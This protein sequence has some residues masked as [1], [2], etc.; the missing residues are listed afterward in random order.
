MGSE[1]PERGCLEA[2]HGHDVAGN[3]ERQGE[4]KALHG[5]RAHEEER[6]RGDESHDVGVKR[7]HDAVARARDGGVLDG[8]AHADLLAEA[9]EH[10]DRGVSRGARGEDHACESRQRQREHSVVRED[11]KKSQVEDSEDHKRAKREES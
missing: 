2:E 5:A 9:L 11:G 8:T 7:G 4:A 1:E 6:K 10:Q 3:A